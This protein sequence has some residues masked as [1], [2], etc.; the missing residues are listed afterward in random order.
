MMALA[1]FL[2]RLHS[3]RHRERLDAEL[4]EE[5][6]E[7]A[8]RRAQALIV[9][10]MAPDEARRRAA[11]AVGNATRLREEARAVWGF[12][13]MQDLRYGLRVLRRSPVFTSVAVLSLAIGIGAAAAVFSLAD[14]FLLRPLAVR[15]P[16]SLVLLR[17]DPMA[18]AIAG[19]I[20]LL[21]SAL[22]G[23]LPARRASRVDPIVALRAE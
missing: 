11:I 7:H 18:L 10:G 13:G 16:D 2:R 15:N 3:A 1:R 23:Y 9:E 14:A 5:I 6:A 4:R 19:A 21:A 12:P 22:A 17:G 8:E 20:L